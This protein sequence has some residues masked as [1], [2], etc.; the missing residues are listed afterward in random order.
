MEKEEFLEQYLFKDLKALKGVKDTEQSYLFT[1][2]DF[3]KILSRAKYYGIGIYT[4][5]AYFKGKAYANTTHEDHKKKATDYSWSQRAFTTF[6]K[7]QAG[8]TYS[9]TY[10]ISPKLLAKESHSEEEE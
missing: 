2:T 7:E 10:K 5:E 4:I 9:A 8:L 3:E 6:K 1:E